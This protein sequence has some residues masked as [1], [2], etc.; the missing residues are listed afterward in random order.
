MSLIGY[1][2]RL[3]YNTGTEGSP[4]WVPV[5]TVRD[6]SLTQEANEVDDT[7]R[8]TAGWRSRRQ[9]LKQWGTEFETIYEPSN[10]AWQAIRENF[11]NGTPS[12]ILVLD[13]DISI[14]GAEGL[15]GFAEVTGFD[16]EEP[17]EDVQINNTTLVGSSEATWVIAA[18]G[19]VTP[20]SGS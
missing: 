5:N 11:Y 17:L 2:G 14:D 19:A 3:Y 12:E 8:T 15:R 1:E 13:Q 9:G 7:S 10:T 20:K 6:V 4:T 16:K 18:S